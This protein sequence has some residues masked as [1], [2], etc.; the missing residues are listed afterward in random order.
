[1]D[2]V[3]RHL[4]TA[5]VAGCVK[6][7]RRQSAARGRHNH[8]INLHTAHTFGCVYG[9]AYRTFSLV[10]IYDKAIFNSARTLMSKTDDAR[11]MRT[12][13]SRRNV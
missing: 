2:V 10:H 5:N 8:M 4:S 13:I 12:P 1:M 7:L 9:L 11:A 6:M 3:D